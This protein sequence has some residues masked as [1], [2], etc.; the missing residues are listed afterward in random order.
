VLNAYAVVF[1]ALLVTG[2]AEDA[3]D[4]RPRVPTA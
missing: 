2:R 4:G 3:A 1:G